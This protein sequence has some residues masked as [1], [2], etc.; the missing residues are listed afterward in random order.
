VRRP[1]E[2]DLDLAEP[3]LLVLRLAEDPGAVAGKVARENGDAAVVE[4]PRRV[5]LLL[6]AGKECRREL[7][8]GEGH[9]E[10]VPPEEPRLEGADPVLESPGDGCAEGEALEGPHPE[11]VAR[12]VDGG[13]GR[14]QG[15]EGGVGEPQHPGRQAR[16][17]GDEVRVGAGRLLLREAHQPL[18]DRRQGGEVDDAP[19]D[20]RPLVVSQRRVHRPEEAPRGRKRPLAELQPRRGSSTGLRTILRWEVR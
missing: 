6:H 18:D 8:G 1:E 7:A 16:V 11:H 9:A 2:H 17:D 3:A 14:P 10:R 19:E 5:E 13:D 15:I 4:E 12:L 20:P